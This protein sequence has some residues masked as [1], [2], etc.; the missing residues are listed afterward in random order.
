MALDYLQQPI[1]LIRC[2]LAVRAFCALRHFRDH[3]IAASL[4]FSRPNGRRMAMHSAISY[5]GLVAACNAAPE[6]APM[7]HDN[8][9]FNSGDFGNYGNFGNSLCVPL[10]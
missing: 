4:K 2:E 7:L 5:R 9:L 8:A 1:D 6:G 10:T 3:L